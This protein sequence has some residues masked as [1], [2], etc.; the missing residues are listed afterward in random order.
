[1]QPVVLSLQTLLFFSFLL[2]LLLLLI[3]AHIDAN[4]NSARRGSREKEKDN[5]ND[6]YNNDAEGDSFAKEAE[7]HCRQ[8][9][10]LQDKK[11]YMQS[12]SRSDFELHNDIDIVC[13]PIDGHLR[14][15]G[16]PIKVDNKDADWNTYQHLHYL[17]YV[18]GFEPKVIYDIGASFL[19]W[20]SQAKVFWPDATYVLFEADPIFEYLYQKELVIH[21]TG[22]MMMM[23]VMMM[24]M[25]MMMMIMT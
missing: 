10:L 18:Q 5:D 14:V 3:P 1:M 2:L 21:E 20:T 4:Q 8:S 22:M 24:M 11:M 13:S 9:L 7:L 12:E 25:M 19:H 17:K 6:N 15:A 23:M 16:Y